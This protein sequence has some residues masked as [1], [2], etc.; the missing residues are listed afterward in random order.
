MKTV[1][2]F[3]GHTNGYNVMHHIHSLFPL[4]PYSPI[5][6]YPYQRVFKYAHHWVFLGSK[7]PHRFVG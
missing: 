3:Q 6:H 1:N 7:G 4:L 2:L 5:L